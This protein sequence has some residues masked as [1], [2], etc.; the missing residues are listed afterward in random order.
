M[1]MAIKEYMEKMGVGYVLQPYETYPWSHYDP[2]EGIT[3]SAD[4]A[5]RQKIETSSAA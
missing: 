3:A 2:D 1:P 5:M 4:V